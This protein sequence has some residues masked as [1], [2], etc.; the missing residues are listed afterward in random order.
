MASYQFLTN[1][2]SNIA[3]SLEEYF[4]NN[5]Q[6]LQ[7]QEGDAVVSCYFVDE[8]AVCVVARW[9]FV[10]KK[11]TAFSPYRATFGGIEFD[12]GIS[13]ETL[14]TF[15]NLTVQYL[16]EKGITSIFLN[17]YPAGYISEVA[18]QK[19][20]Q[21]LV[22]A[23][24]QVLRTEHNYEISITEKSF[25]T[26]L[27]NKR[28]K[29]LL[30]KSLRLGFRFEEIIQPNFPQIHTFIARSRERKGRPMTMDFVSFV[31][32]FETFTEAF[33][34]FGVWDTQ[35][36][37]AV[38]V[39]IRINARILYTFYLAD[40]EA[41]LPFSPTILLVAGIYDYAQAQNYQVLDLGIAS[42]KGILNEGLAKFKE[43]LGGIFSEKEVYEWVNE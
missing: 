20:K 18:R 16:Q 12:P 5:P 40:H 23:H 9:S 19:L 25:L 32:H 10:L 21:V 35:T 31:R 28:S 1:L 3:F 11:I 30:Q 34:A 29:Q 41:Y 17:S 15:V 43:R 22:D 13:Q 27:N 2:P 33:K 37:I 26:Q 39:T 7:Q 14:H 38:G 42:E 8:D 24:F 6:H 4:F 36:L